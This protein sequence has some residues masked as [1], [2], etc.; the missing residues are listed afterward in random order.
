[1]DGGP[2]KF[3][4]IFIL[5]LHSGKE[6]T[7]VFLRTR[8]ALFTICIILSICL[9]AAVIPRA[10]T[11]NTVHSNLAIERIHDLDDLDVALYDYL[12][13]P[14]N[15]NQT[16]FN[17]N[18][19]AIGKSHDSLFVMKS[20][21]DVTK[22]GKLFYFP[23]FSVSSSCAV[24][25]VDYVGHANGMAIDDNN[26]YL[27]A[28][29]E[30]SQN[31]EPHDDH[32]I[33][34]IPRSVIHSKALIKFANPSQDVLIEEEDPTIPGVDGFTWLPF[35]VGNITTGQPTGPYPYTIGRITCYDGNGESRNGNFIVTYHIN[36][37]NSFEYNHTAY[38]RAKL[39]TYN[40]SEVL[41][42]SNSL[43]DIFVIKNT[44]QHDPND[45]LTYANGNILYSSECGFFD[46]KFLKVTVDN[47]GRRTKNVILWADIDS[48]PSSVYINSNYYR[49]FIPDK[50]NLNAKN[51]A[52]PDIGN[53]NK[54]YSKFEI[55][56]MAFDEN[57]NMYIA[58]N[59]K[60]TR[61]TDNTPYS[62]FEAHQN[63][64]NEDPI[65]D[66]VFEITRYANSDIDRITPLGWELS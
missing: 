64:Y 63:Y 51:E 40:G 41:L 10:I 37:N 45:P 11:G 39:I 38:T 48:T 43:N 56:S 5:P 47:Y 50:I 24:L 13:D 4:I 8:K 35:M 25:T 30:I 66:G 58:A 61:S 59:T 16:Y 57:N 1:M 2:P 7:V 15:N 52:D 22:K 28:S 36:N 23:N 18:G 6:R 31:I 19:M 49:C 33:L 17:T 26:I 62:Y 54:M 44:I 29:S 9:T 42:L 27:T 20:N 53:S 3:Y 46:P 60:Y 14:G 32:F 55:E 12:Y 65:P 21:D 34:K